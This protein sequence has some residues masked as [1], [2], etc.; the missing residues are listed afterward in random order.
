MLLSNWIT[1]QMAHAR[2]SHVLLS[3]LQLLTNFVYANE[4]AKTSCVISSSSTP[5][6]RRAGGNNQPKAPHTLLLVVTQTVIQQSGHPESNRPLPVVDIPLHDACCALL[7]SLVVNTECLQWMIRFGLVASLVGKARD[8]LKR[9]GQTTKKSD[10]KDARALSNLLGVLAST[11]CTEDGRQTIASSAGNELRDIFGDILQSTDEDVLRVGSRLLR[12]LAFTKNQLSVWEGCMDSLV[13]CL[14][15]RADRSSDL[16]GQHLSSALW[17]LVCDN[18]KAKA[19]LLA[20][21]NTL[22]RLEAVGSKGELLKC[23]IQ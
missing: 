22:R 20:R 21:P 4:N 18:Q 5:P 23:H 19:M 9:D 6:M 10:P 2:G 3:A 14:E 11:A 16:V 12:N 17:C 7:S 13:T 15:H 8:Q 1:M